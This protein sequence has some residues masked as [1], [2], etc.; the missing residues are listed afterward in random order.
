MVAKYGFLILAIAMICCAHLVRTKRW[1]LFIEIY[2]EPN[3][4]TLL[5]SL[6]VGH[7]INFFIPFKLGDLVRAL[8]A[9]RYMK[10]GKTLSLTTVILDRYLDI[11]SVG[12]IFLAVFFVNGY[13][14]LRTTIRFYIILM[15]ALLSC[16]GLVFVGKAWIKKLLVLFAGIFNPSIELKILKLSWS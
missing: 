4:R 11:I 16:T 9:A 1:E 10:N 3:E 5:Q 14:Y 8:F 12:T 6:S 2:E 7:L 15:V 13:E